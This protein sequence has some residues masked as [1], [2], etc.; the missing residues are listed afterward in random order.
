MSE[1]KEETPEKKEPKKVSKQEQK[2]QA[3]QKEAVNNQKNA[4]RTEAIRRLDGVVSQVS[5]SRKD[6]IKLNDDVKL[7][8]VSIAKLAAYEKGE[9]Q[10]ETQEEG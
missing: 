7:L 6:H 8:F 2:R 4:A 9:G 5:L 10:E 3:A 1:D